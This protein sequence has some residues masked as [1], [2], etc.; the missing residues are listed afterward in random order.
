MARIDSVNVCAW[1]DDG[2]LCTFDLELS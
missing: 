2:L 1:I